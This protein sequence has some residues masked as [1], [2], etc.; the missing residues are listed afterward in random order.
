MVKAFTAPKKEEPVELLLS[1]L[2]WIQNPAGSSSHIWICVDKH[3]M[4]KDN[5]F[6]GSLDR[7]FCT[8]TTWTN[9]NA[10]NYGHTIDYSLG[11]IFLDLYNVLKKEYYE[12]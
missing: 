4:L 5:V 9:Y 8:L 2:K 11:D 10:H 6:Y 12:S 7:F 3:P 1:D